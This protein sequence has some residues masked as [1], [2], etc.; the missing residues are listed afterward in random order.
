MVFGP[1]KKFLG[2][3]AFNYMIGKV[4]KMKINVKGAFKTVKDAVIVSAVY[5]IA[6][7]VVS[8]LPPDI[9]AIVGPKI[10]TAVLWLLGA[11]GIS[12]AANMIPALQNKK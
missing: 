1:V 9:Q 11:I 8:A 3:L 12:G 5:S 7:V 6:T 10:N 4:K 2:K